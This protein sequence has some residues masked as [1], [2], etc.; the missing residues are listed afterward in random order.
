MNLEELENCTPTHIISNVSDIEYLHINCF[1]YGGETIQ[2]SHLQFIL[3]NG[4]NI[5]S[6][7]FGKYGGYFILAEK[8]V[9]P[10]F[11]QQKK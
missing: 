6:I 9:S 11:K 4:F 2:H 8:D 3:D 1:G 5:V 7:N 10:Y